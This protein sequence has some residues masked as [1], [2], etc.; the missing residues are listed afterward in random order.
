[1]RLQA[2]H[3]ATGIGLLSTAGAAHAHGSGLFLIFVGVP[4][5]LLAYLVFSVAC[6]LSARKGQRAYQAILCVMFVPIW[7]VLFWTPWLSSYEVNLRPYEVEWSLILPSLL[8]VAGIAIAVKRR[9]KR[10]A[11]KNS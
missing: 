1:M 9:L 10:N 7:G 3:I 2:T 6:V 4:F 11:V 8:L 5:A